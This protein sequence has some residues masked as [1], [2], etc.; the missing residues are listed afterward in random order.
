MATFHLQPSDARLVY[1]AVV[2]HLGRPGSETD[3]ATLRPHELGLGPLRD[4]LDA[5]L[6]PLREGAAPTAEAVALVLS[7]YQ[8]TRL[9]TALHGTVNELKQFEMAGGRSAVP[10]FAAAF[11][12]LFPPA[13]S[14]PAALDHDPV[15]SGPAALDL[16]PAAVMLRRRLD[17][18]VREAEQQVAAAREA[19][20]PAAAAGGEPPLWRRL[21][22]RA[23]R[24][25]RR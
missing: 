24:P 22:R 1:L 7:P 14:D 12:R 13:A 21:A 3:P 23:V 5:Q 17:A 2:Y 6:G 16:V 19:E 4:A 11:A 18:A 25:W 10:G 20:A 15:A 9:G 8:L